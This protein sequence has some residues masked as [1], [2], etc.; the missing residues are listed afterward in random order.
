M[1]KEAYLAFLIIL[2]TCLMAFSSVYTPSR[3][4]ASDTIAPSSDMPGVVV[5]DSITDRYEPVRFD[6]REHVEMTDTCGECHHQHGAEKT[7]TCRE[8]HKIDPSAFRK[9]VGTSK[10]S[11]CKECHVEPARADNLNIPGLKAAYHRACFGCH[12]E[13]GSV[14]VDPKGCTETCHEKRGETGK[15]SR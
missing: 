9:S 14:G 15:L 12:R 8:C 5:L 1:R 10:F 13:V 4:Q 7:L 11:A 6:H 3:T 2:G